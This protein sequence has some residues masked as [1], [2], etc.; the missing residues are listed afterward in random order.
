MKV[1]MGL[2]QILCLTFTLLLLLLVCCAQSIAPMDAVL[3]ELLHPSFFDIPGQGCLHSGQ[4]RYAGGENW[5]C[6]KRAKYSVAAVN[7][8]SG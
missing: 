7:C 6:E 4:A 3:L 2:G 1:E 8:G 5:R